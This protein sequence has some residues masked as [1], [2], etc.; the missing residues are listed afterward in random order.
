ME[1]QAKYLSLGELSSFQLVTFVILLSLQHEAD[2][3]VVKYTTLHGKKEIFVKR[4]I[5]P[6]CV[7]KYGEGIFHFHLV[8]ENIGFCMT[9]D[10]KM[11]VV[12]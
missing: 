11:Y 8:H 4:I 6:I 2:G 3:R 1:L 5:L 9:N 7:V 10:V 12:Y